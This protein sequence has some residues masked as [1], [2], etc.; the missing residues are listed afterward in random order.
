MDIVFATVVASLPALNSLIDS[1][2][3]RVRT[4]A[5]RASSFLRASIRSLDGSKQNSHIDKSGWS[6]SAWNGRKPNHIGAG[7]RKIESIDSLQIRANHPEWCRFRAPEIYRHSSWKAEALKLFSD[8]W[9]RYRATGQTDTQMMSRFLGESGFCLAI[10]KDHFDS[11]N[12][13]F[14]TVT[15]FPNTVPWWSKCSL[16]SS[17]Q[18]LRKYQRGTEKLAP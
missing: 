14:R 2:A 13:F 8:S 15:T 3:V 16:W 10:W 9:R 5:S 12:T 11:A 7:I 6:R 18:H 1:S 17:L 4:W